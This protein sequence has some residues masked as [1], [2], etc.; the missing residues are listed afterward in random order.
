MAIFLSSNK[1]AGRGKV[2]EGEEGN[3][4]VQYDKAGETRCL[5]GGSTGS[6]TRQGGD[7][8]KRNSSLNLDNRPIGTA[9]WGQKKSVIALHRS[10]LKKVEARSQSSSKTREKPGYKGGVVR[11]HYRS[12]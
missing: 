1:Y 4:F 7:K 3:K 5:K 6:G 9:E 2:G 10:H 11:C 12:K 8:K